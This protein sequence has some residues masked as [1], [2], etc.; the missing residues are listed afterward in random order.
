[1]CML[2]VT[3]VSCAAPL[4]NR[5]V[6]GYLACRLRAWVAALFGGAPD[7]SAEHPNA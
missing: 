4:A 5:S 6:R 7:A 3:L 2:E 1:M